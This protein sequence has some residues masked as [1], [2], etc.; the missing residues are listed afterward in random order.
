MF[1]GHFGIAY[2]SKSLKRNVSLGTSF[3]AAQF[4]D[5]LW[6]LFLLMG[7]EKVE[8]DPGNTALT[9]LNFL[10]YPFSHSMVATC[11]WAL[12]F[13][14][15]FY[16]IRRS[17]RGAWLVAALVCSHWILDFITHR[18]DLPLTMADSYKVGL[19][20]W[21]HKIAAIIIEM[22]LF[23]TGVYFYLKN[24]RAKNRM[25]VNSTWGLI[26]FLILIYALN[27]AGDPPPDSASIAIAGF[28]QWLLIVWAYWCDRLRMPA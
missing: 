14:L 24:T 6:P 4:I 13:G 16:I 28:A 9:P 11:I 7:I 15:V 27:I 26:I 2:A 23:I 21:N 1:L 17:P 18:P 10:S 25:G 12:I 22:T 5:L 8:I 20:L 19:G 3:L